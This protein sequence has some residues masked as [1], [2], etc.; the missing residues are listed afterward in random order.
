MMYTA[1]S[2]ATKMKPYDATQ[3]SLQVVLCVAFNNLL[4]IFNN[5]LP[6]KIDYSKIYAMLFINNTYGQTG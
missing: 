3:T 6:L 4:S 5:L 1:M 2:A